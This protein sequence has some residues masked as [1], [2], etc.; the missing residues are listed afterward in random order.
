M[1]ENVLVPISSEFYPKQVLKRSL[2]LGKK[3]K[4]KLNFLYIIEEKNLEQTDKL[5][6]SYISE[7]DM[8][9]TKKQIIKSQK[10]TAEELVFKD[11]ALILTKNKTLYFSHRN[12]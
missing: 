10:Q 2:F 1:F 7:Y 12:Q 9:Q 8:S 3:F 11:A 6:D 4:S 5:I